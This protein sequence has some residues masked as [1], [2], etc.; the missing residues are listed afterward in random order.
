MGG[1]L[2]KPQ[3]V[4]PPPVPA[5]PPVPVVDEDEVGTQARKRRSRGRQETF[6]TGNLIPDTG[7]RKVLG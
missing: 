4:K 1:L 3:V 5:P 7:K 6:L 2:D